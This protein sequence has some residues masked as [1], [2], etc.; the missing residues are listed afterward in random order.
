MNE[1]GVRAR[2]LQLESFNEYGDGW[3]PNNLPWGTHQRLNIFYFGIIPLQMKAKVT[4][5]GRSWDP[6]FNHDVI[7]SREYALWYDEGLRNAKDIVL[8]QYY[9]TGIDPEEQ[10]RRWNIPPARNFDLKDIRTNVA[11]KRWMKERL[12]VRHCDLNDEGYPFDRDLEPFF[13]SSFDAIPFIASNIFGEMHNISEWMDMEDLLGWGILQA[14]PQ[15]PP[16]APPQALPQAPPNSII[17]NSMAAMTREHCE[18]VRRTALEIEKKYEPVNIEHETMNDEIEHET[19]L[20]SRIERGRST[21]QN[22]KAASAV[23]ERHP[24]FRMRS[25]DANIGRRAS[26]RMDVQPAV[27]IKMTDWDT[28]EHGEMKKRKIELDPVRMDVQPA[29]Q[30]QI[31][32]DPSEYVPLYEFCS[33][34]E[35]K[36]PVGHTSAK[37][38]LLS[39]TCKRMS[40]ILPIEWIMKVWRAIN[41]DNKRRDNWTQRHQ[42]S[43]FCLTLQCT[44]SEAIVR[45]LQ[46]CGVLQQAG[47]VRIGVFEVDRITGRYPVIC[48]NEEVLC[49]AFNDV[50]G[51]KYGVSALYAAWIAGAQSETRRKLAEKNIHVDNLRTKKGERSTL[52]QKLNE[53]SSIMRM[54]YYEQIFTDFPFTFAWDFSSAPLNGKVS[55]RPREDKKWDYSWMQKTVVPFY[56]TTDGDANLTDIQL[57]EECST[58]GY[59]WID[60]KTFSSGLHLTH[61]TYYAHHWGYMQICDML[62]CTLGDGSTRQNIIWCKCNY[63]LSIAVGLDKMKKSIETY[64][65]YVCVNTEIDVESGGRQLV[66]NFI[67]DDIAKIRKEY[68]LVQIRDTEIHIQ[69]SKLHIIVSD[70][71]VADARFFTYRS[72]ALTRFKIPSGPITFNVNGNLC[73]RDAYTNAFGIGVPSAYD[74][75]LC[76]SLHGL[77]KL[78]DATGVG[79]IDRGTMKRIKQQLEKDSISWTDITGDAQLVDSIILSDEEKAR[80]SLVFND[81]C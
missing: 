73:T 39:N 3:A 18:A 80:L 33:E 28:L 50:R 79:T 41:W 59:D 75:P 2:L 10:F 11:V 40:G 19:M 54:T 25:P 55:D 9:D 20:V 66:L 22:I 12:S 32:L 53:D 68:N 57:R 62:I 6:Y 52:L 42:Y 72:E 5:R 44:M 38:Q 17:T 35:K 15:A 31:E 69:V 71:L 34:W 29:V 14:L 49:E 58:V 60:K 51:R 48:F 74:D 26:V 63:K 76:I 81:D 27:Q 46:F 64:I 23:P 67:L 4:I 45:G 7:K 47:N 43:V 1:D 77:R 36:P 37:M 61:G 24:I 16:Q 78:K 65:C 8:P 70:N 13:V 30:V 21:G 56:C